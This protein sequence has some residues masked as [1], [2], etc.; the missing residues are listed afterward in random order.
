MADDGDFFLEQKG[1][2]KSYTGVY[3]LENTP[4][5]LE[6]E[7]SANVIWGEKFEKGEKGENVKQKG[8]KGKEKEKWKGEKMRSE[9]VK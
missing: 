4:P 9:R 7:I 6:G 3:I 1:I 2:M 5:P 8:R